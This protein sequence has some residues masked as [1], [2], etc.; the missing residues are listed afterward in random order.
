MNDVNNF[1]ILLYMKTKI[2]NLIKTMDFTDKILG[3]E[4]Q[5]LNWLM[6]I[7]SVLNRQQHQFQ[8][9]VKVDQAQRLWGFKWWL[10]MFLAPMAP[11]N[12]LQDKTL[13][14]T[15]LRNHKFFPA[16]RIYQSFKMVKTW[17]FIKIIKE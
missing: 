17:I 12:Q 9:K 2:S 1:R 10:E 4:F 8:A 15:L 7:K 11:T 14:K 13:K 5:V 6:I 3:V 16:I